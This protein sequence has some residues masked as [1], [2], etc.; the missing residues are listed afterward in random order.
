MFLELCRYEGV[1][2]EV[3]MQTIPMKIDVRT[4]RQ[5]SQPTHPQYTHQVNEEIEKLKTSIEYPIEC[6]S[7]VSMIKVVPRKNG[8]I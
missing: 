4:I 2:L 5:M 7:W 6:T 3:V 1:P 8:K